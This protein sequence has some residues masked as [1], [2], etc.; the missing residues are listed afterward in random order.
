MFQELV[1]QK[2]SFLS[3]IVQVVKRFP[4][5]NFLGLWIDFF[6]Y[7]LNPL[8]SK[9]KQIDLL[10][11]INNIFPNFIPISLNIAQLGVV[12]AGGIV[13]DYREDEEIIIARPLPGP[14]MR[15]IPIDGHQEPQHTSDVEF[16]L[17]YWVSFIEA[18]LGGL[19]EYC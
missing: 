15:E 13:E 12:S 6:K 2:L 9:L 19:G 1:F 5:G 11:A 10:V 8:R 7:I 16:G 3:E 17:H 18:F 14:K 4:S